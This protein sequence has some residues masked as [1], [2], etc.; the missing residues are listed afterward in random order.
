M[1]SPAYGYAAVH[2]SGP[3]WGRADYDPRRGTPRSRAAEGF[4]RRFRLTASPLYLE[5][6]AANAS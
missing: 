4:L 2:Q 5:F 1:I 3:G 6:P